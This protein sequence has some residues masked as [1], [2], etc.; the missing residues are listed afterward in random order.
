[1]EAKRSGWHNAHLVLR[2]IA[3]GWSLLSLGFVALF[4]IGELFHPTAALP[5]TARDMIGLS[6]FPCGVSLGMI[7]AWRREGLGGAVTVASLLAFYALLRFADGRFPRG[8]YFA[9]VAAPGA[10]FLVSWAVS[11]WRTKPAGP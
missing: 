4:A 1:V 5:T 3:R 6:L 10:L 8:P 2:W 11:R 7:L 9:L